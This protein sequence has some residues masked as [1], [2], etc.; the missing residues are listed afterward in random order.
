MNTAQYISLFFSM[1]MLANL[2]QAQGISYNYGEV[3]F[4]D[5]E[6]GVV[7]GDAR[8]RLP[9]RA[10][11][12]LVGEAADGRV[13]ATVNGRKDRI[14]RR[15]SHGSGCGCSGVVIGTRLV[16]C[17]RNQCACRANRR[18]EDRGSE[19]AEVLQLAFHVLELL[20]GEVVG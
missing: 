9:L 2:A 4:L 18:S 20:G 5:S 15:A 16:R 12:V 1:L 17:G 19:I 3:R 7:D 13:K 8:Q 6:V 10:V 11:Q 14:R